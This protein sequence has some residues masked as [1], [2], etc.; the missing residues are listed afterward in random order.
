M[1]LPWMQKSQT[2]KP[3]QSIKLFFVIGTISLISLIIGIQTWFSIS[4]FRNSMEVKIRENLK[5]QAGEAVNKLDARFVQIGKY[6][7]LLAYDMEAMPTYDSDLLLNIIDKYIT[8]DPL[9]VGSGF[10]FEPNIYQQGLKYYGPYKYRDDKGQIVLTWEYSNAEYDYFKYDWYKIGLATK[11]KVAW[12]EPYEDAV[13]KVAMITSASPVKKNG[14]VVGVTTV[15]VGLKEYE[16]YI[17]NIKIGETGYGFVITHDGYYLGYKEQEKNLKEKINEDPNEKIKQFGNQILAANEIT[18]FK[19]S[20]FNEEQFIAVA[21]IGNTGMRL[22]LVYPAAEAYREINHTLFITISIF[23]VAVL[24]LT[25]VIIMV[26]NAKISRPLDRLIADAEKIAQG[27]LTTAIQ[28]T[29][30]DEIG[31]LAGHFN[32]M[33]A[34]LRKIITHVMQSTEHVAA[35]AQQLTATTEQSAHATNEVAQAINK[36]VQ[37]NEQQ[38]NDLN[39]AVTVVEQM[40]ISMQ[41]VADSAGAATSTS[42][43]TAATAHTGSNTIHEAIRQMGNIEKTI[44]HSAEVVSR[45][46]ERSKEIGQIVD[47]ISGIAG[48]TNLL[49]LNAAIEA[50]RA[51][52]QGRGFAVVADEVRKLAEQSQEAAKQIAVLIQE[53]QGETDRA[54]VAMN[55]GTD[56]VK[57]GAQVVNKTENAFREIALLINEVVTQVRDISEASQQMTV[58]SGQVVDLVRNIDKVG[59]GNSEQTESVSA[60][61]QEQSAAITEIA[62]SSQALA[63]QAQEL[64]NSIGKFKV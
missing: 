43:R 12:T 17:R 34:S 19:T 23:V 7:E 3:A 51:G 9:I 55:E 38:V 24:L 35:S 11:D 5:Y 42:D 52:E 57:L 22:V 6:T 59:K 1:K 21:P 26:F 60:A 40:S 44:T 10:W 33:A 50:A 45:L 4:Q 14:Q 58:A 64:R 54:V 13:T 41:Q 32:N 56:E 37:G 36:V 29:S 16:E 31:K 20:A 49:A 15:D 46:G 47:T 62:Q 18:L 53:I 39:D 48:Q 2:K 30:N 8:S 27:D 61:T 63:I 28:V 25:F